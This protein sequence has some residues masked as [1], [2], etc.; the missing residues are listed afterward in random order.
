MRIINTCDLRTKEERIYYYMFDKNKVRFLINNKEIIYY[1]KQN[2]VVIMKN[3][4]TFATQI[5]EKLREEALNHK[6]N[7]EMT[8]EIR[9]S[10][11]TDSK[12]NIKVN[13]NMRTNVPHVYA[14]GDCIDG[15]RQVSKA[16]YDGMTA[17]YALI[18]EI[19]G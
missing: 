9:K 6:K 2:N 3:C 18:K 19:K 17:A 1:Y 16:M 12:K 15:V 14:I 4:K 7:E 13:E 10:V 8:N 5:C 11:M